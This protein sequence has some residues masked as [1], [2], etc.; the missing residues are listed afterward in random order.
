MKQKSK[1][2][3]LKYLTYFTQIGLTLVVPPVLYT[4]LAWWCARR[5]GWGNWTVLLGLLLGIATTI[6]E[7]RKLMLFM[8]KQA[9]QSEQEQKP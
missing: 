2:T 1:W 9:K 3:T 8:E 5:F 6:L 7:M 4:V